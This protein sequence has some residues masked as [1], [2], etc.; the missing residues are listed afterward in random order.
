MKEHP[1]KAKEIIT[2]WQEDNPAKETLWIIKNGLRSEKK[3]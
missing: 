2:A 3:V 1:D